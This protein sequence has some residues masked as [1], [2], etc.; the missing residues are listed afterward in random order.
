[1]KFQ[2]GSTEKPIE[3][4]LRRGLREKTSPLSDPAFDNAA[5]FFKRFDGFTGGKS[6]DTTKK[7][8]RDVC[9][10]LYALL[11]AMFDYDPSKRPSAEKAV[12]HLENAKQRLAGVHADDPF[13]HVRTK[14]QFR[15]SKDDIDAFAQRMGMDTTKQALSK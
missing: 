15:P 1:M 2:D 13:W 11:T 12:E 5:S 9:D 3:T 6:S 8:Y 10:D 7:V 4:F 14:I